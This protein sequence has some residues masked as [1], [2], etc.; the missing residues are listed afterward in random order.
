MRKG[1][2]RG[3]K[4]QIAIA[5]VIPMVVDVETVRIEIADT[6]AI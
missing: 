1:V 3:D 6:V 5:I 2:L 4:A